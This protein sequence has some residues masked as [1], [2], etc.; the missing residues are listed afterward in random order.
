MSNINT[1]E[2]VP[3]DKAISLKDEVQSIHF[4]ICKLEALSA[5]KSYV[6]CEV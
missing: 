6:S 5:I 2:P 3:V 4:K 1:N